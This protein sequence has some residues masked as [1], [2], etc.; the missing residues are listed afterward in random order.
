[1]ASTGLKAIATEAETWSCLAKFRFDSRSQ[2]SYHIMQFS[3]RQCSLQINT[4]WLRS[5]ATN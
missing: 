2:K 3:V 4:A 5:L 1:M